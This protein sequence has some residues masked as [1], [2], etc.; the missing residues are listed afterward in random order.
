MRGAEIWVNIINAL[1]TYYAVNSS[2]SSS[3][4][5]Y[6][7]GEPRNINI[8]ISYDLGSFFNP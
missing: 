8:G 2:R 7:L 3:G 6:T 4:R 1:D 5:N